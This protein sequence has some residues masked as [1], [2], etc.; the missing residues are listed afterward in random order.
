MRVLSGPVGKEKI[1]YEAPP[2]DRVGAEMDIFLKWWN[3]PPDNLDGLVRAALAHF[4]FV[5]IHPFEDGNGRIARAIT[6]MALAQ[7]EGTE[8]WVLSI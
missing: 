1:H 5:S 8:C 7:D 3:S 4:W 6:D 2:A